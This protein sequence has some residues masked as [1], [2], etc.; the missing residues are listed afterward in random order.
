MQDMPISQQYLLCILTPK[1][2]IPSFGTEKALC[3]SAA[4]VLELLMEEVLSLQEK[5]LVISSPLPQRLSHLMPVYQLISEKQ[6]VS[7]NRVVQTFSLSLSD[8]WIKR[9]VDSLGSALLAKGCVNIEKG[10][11]FVEKNLYPPISVAVDRVIQSLRVQ[12]LSGNPLSED[13]VSLTV[14]LEKSG[15]LRKHFS[16]LERETVK[17]RLR[18]IRNTPQNQLV[19]K[20]IEYLDA[21]FLLCVIAAT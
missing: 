19:Q 6:P 9:L 20:A 12:L 5:K 1:G 16:S 14:L 7:F 17:Q 2:E 15:E 4:A 10:G 11:I 18:E 3:L 8:T 21:L 13:T